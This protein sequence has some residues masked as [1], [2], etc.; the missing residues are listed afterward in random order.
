M[1]RPEA[2]GGQ[3]H[4][5]PAPAPAPAGDDQAGP[6]R[7]PAC[8]FQ[9]RPRNTVCGGVNGSLGCRRGRDAAGP[10]PIA[11]AGE[12]WRCGSCGFMNQPHNSRC[13]G[14]GHL[15]CKQPR[16]GM[17]QQ[18]QQRWLCKCGFNN[19]WYNTVCG[20]QQ[21]RLGCKA[22][23][24]RD[25]AGLRQAPTLAENTPVAMWDLCAGLRCMCSPVAEKPGVVSVMQF[26]VLDSVHAATSGDDFAQVPAN[27]G[28]FVVRLQGIRK[29]LATGVDVVALQEL[30]CFAEGVRHGDAVRAMLT[31]LNYE[32]RFHSQCLVA[33][34]KD[35]FDIVGQPE[36]IPRSVAVRL[37]TKGKKAPPGGQGGQE[38]CVCSTH[39]AWIPV[40]DA[41]QDPG[42]SGRQP[43]A[44]GAQGSPR[45]REECE[46]LQQQACAELAAA[47]AA[48]AQ[49]QP[50]LLLGDFNAQP[51]SASYREMIQQGYT[52]AYG[53]SPG[54]EPAVTTAKP[55]GDRFAGCIDY[56][57]GANGVE[58]ASVSKLPREADCRAEHGGLPTRWCPSDHLPLGAAARLPP[59]RGGPS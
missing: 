43:H 12:S 24:P 40:A 17:E 25:L 56:I 20:G 54:G 35:R 52:S 44:D 3:Q 31:E 26:N 9:N 22:P 34:Q 16:P 21:G 41:A 29:L 7:C 5:D 53:S 51:S 37:R 32:W 8:G 58:F 38:F 1:A 10:T 59:P 15:G 47:L 23:R 33:W 18:V 39:Q 50:V 27:V 13:G 4:S 28:D 45:T 48:F 30:R 42:E 46:R 14:T 36:R 2:A 49:G 55:G 6:W 57:W 19:L 11:P